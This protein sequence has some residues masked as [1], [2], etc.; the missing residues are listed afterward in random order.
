MTTP[1]DNNS[2][3]HSKDVLKAS[4]WK[5]TFVRSALTFFQTL[6]GELAVFSAADIEKWGLDG[7]PW[8]VMGSVAIFA[9]L[10]SVVTSVSRLA[11]KRASDKKKV[12]TSPAPAPTPAV[13]NVYNSAPKK[14]DGA[15]APVE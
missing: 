6:G 3:D 8:G 1:T 10:T 4:F 5:D 13:Q 11:G 7:L 12:P 15:T 9:A 2:E 14:E